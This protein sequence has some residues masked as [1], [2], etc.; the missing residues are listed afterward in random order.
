MTRT[1]GH[2]L[3][4]G[5]L[6]GIAAGIVLALLLGLPTLRLRADYLAIV[7]IAAA[8]IIRLI[9][10]A[11][12]L[13]RYTGGSAG[14]NGVANEFQDKWNFIWT[15]ERRYG[16]RIFGGRLNFRFTGG[17]LWEILVGW[18]LVLVC[19][20]RDVAAGVESVGPGAALDPRGRGRRPVA[21]QERVPVQD[22][23][24]GARGTLRNASAGSTTPCSRTR[25]SRTTT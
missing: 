16:R 7:T 24:A 5:V 9:I 8:E 20:A 2:P 17:E 3:W 25:C 6:V 11:A 23:V 10:R 1:Y 13:Q 21:R 22:A 15:P 12:R 14:L 18:S 19:L 4:A